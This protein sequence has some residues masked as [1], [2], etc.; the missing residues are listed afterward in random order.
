LQDLSRQRDKEVA[1]DLLVLRHPCV[2][3]LVQD[4]DV[5]SVIGFLLGKILGW[6]FGCRAKELEDL[7]S[8]D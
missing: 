3:L 4:R 2:V 1:Q 5:L 6:W 7:R 8:S